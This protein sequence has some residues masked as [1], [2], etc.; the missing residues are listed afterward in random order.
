VTPF[1]PPGTYYDPSYGR[2]YSGPQDFTDKVVSGFYRERDQERY[3]ERDFGT[4]GIDLNASGA[5]DQT[6]IPVRAFHIAEKKNLKVR[7][8]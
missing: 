4:N 1:L 2:H 5:I 8:E 7:F 3:D 6:P